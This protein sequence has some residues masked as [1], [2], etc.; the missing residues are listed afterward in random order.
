MRNNNNQKILVE[1]IIKYETSFQYY[2][3]DSFLK[4]N[5]DLFKKGY[6]LSNGELSYINSNNQKT[7]IKSKND[8]ILLLRYART[9][10]YTIKIFYEKELIDS[11]INDFKFIEIKNVYSDLNTDESFLDL[12][13]MNKCNET[14]NTL[15]TINEIVNNIDKGSIFQGIKLITNLLKKKY[16]YAFM[17]NINGYNNI[18]DNDKKIDFNKIPNNK[19]TDSIKLEYNLP[20]IEDLLNDYKFD[21]FKNDEDDILNKLK[22]QFEKI[23]ENKNIYFLYQ[24]I[25]KASQ[26]S[27]LK[28]NIN[29]KTQLNNNNNFNE[30]IFQ[31]EIINSPLINHFGVECKNCHI[32]PI[33]NIRYKCPKCINYNLCEKCEEKNSIHLFHPHTDF[34]LIRISENNILDNPYSYQCLTK[35][36]VFNIKK[37][38]IIDDQIVIKNILF[39][40]NFILPWPGLNNTYIKCDKSLSTIFCEKVFLPSLVLGKTVHVNFIFKKIK[41]IPKN[42]YK[43]IANFMVYKEKYGDP[44]EIFIN[45]M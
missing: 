45:L 41:N 26:I 14:F 42:K 39:K 25:A 12:Q 1:I 22:T 3:P 20:P 5:E 10:P 43:C 40:N 37:E 9:V 7:I 33:I 8:F 28:N 34:I 18:V 29:I 36:L 15:N 4:F 13:K 21:L 44:L 2:L 16:F 19:I 11:F 6:P 30:Q 17:L 31:T 32:K 23:E 38:E 24:S 35:N 27:K